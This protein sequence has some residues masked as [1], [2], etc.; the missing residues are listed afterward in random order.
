MKNTGFE[1]V[2]LANPEEWSRLSDA[3]VCFTISALYYIPALIRYELYKLLC[4]KYN[5][6]V[7]ISTRRADDTLHT[8]PLI[9]GT[10]FKEVKRFH[11]R[12]RG[13]MKASYTGFIY[14][15]EV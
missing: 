5:T 12:V 10:G 15:R 8:F 14:E 1:V 3:S 7:T 13:E 4:K 9:Y 2:N 6:I 11:A